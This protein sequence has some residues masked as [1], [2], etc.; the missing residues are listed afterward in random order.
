MQQRSFGCAVQGG[1]CH[2][3]SLLLQQSPTPYLPCPP[4]PWL[5]PPHQAA[6][7]FQ[8]TAGLYA[9]LKEAEA[10]KVDAPRPADLTPECCTMLERL[11]L[12][13]AQVGGGLRVCAGV[14]KGC[15]ACLL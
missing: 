8:E 5:H 4:L 3:L 1:C 9:L 6:Q 11:M 15:I 13:Q 2:H 10:S 12:A 7:L 14:Y